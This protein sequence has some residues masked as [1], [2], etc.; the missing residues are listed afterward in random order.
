MAGTTNR[1]LSGAKA[2]G[3]RRSIS[4]CAAAGIELTIA[5]SLFASFSYSAQETTDSVVQ[6]L[7]TE[8]CNPALFYGEPERRDSLISVLAACKKEGLE[9]LIDLLD[10][11]WA[12]H[13]EVL[14]LA[15]DKKGPEAREAII[16]RIKEKKTRPGIPALLAVF[17]KMG[18]P[19]DEKYLVGALKSKDPAA[20]ICAARCLASF[21][22]FTKSYKLLTPFLT[23]S[24]PQVCLAAV[25][26]L[27]QIYCRDPEPLLAGRAVKKIKPLLAD[28]HPLV[29]FS[30]EEA[31][32]TIQGSD[33][34]I[35]LPLYL[36]P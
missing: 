27:G 10:T 16:R 22:S 29:R 19:G 36:L 18:R 12:V 33:R 7:V 1:V 2:P 30:A 28:P 15:L 23:S 9:E 13:F 24:H 8:A 17:E 5:L 14:R 6:A 4:R 25:W 32:T 3:G 34:G 11:P 35:P 20:Q 31:M 21:G 26:A